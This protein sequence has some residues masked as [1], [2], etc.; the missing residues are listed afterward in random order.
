MPNPSVLASAAVFLG[1]DIG[2]SRCRFEWWPAGAAPGG[3]APSVQPAVHGIEATVQGL[4]TALFAAC[5]ERV[6]TAAVGALAGVGDAATSA[7]I[8][9]G[10]RA[11]GIAFPVAVVGDV[12]AAVAAALADGPGLLL[13]AGTGSFA[14]ARAGDGSLHRVGGRGYLLG[15]QGS[16]YD[17]VRRAAAA[18]L[19]ALDGLGPATTL[20]AALTEAFG[21]PSPARLG[22]VLQ[23]LAPGEVAGRLPHVLAAA[24]AGDQV[25]NAVLADGVAA[26]AM[27][28]AAAVR[29]AG[30]SFGGLPIAIGGGVLTGVPT[31]AAALAGRL[32]SL[33][34][35][36]PRVIAP[37]AAALGA[38]WLAAGWHEQRQPQQEWVHRV[39]I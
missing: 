29:A 9:A 12:M 39:A 17:L 16:G 8:V 26:L 31:I 34:A 20:T 28:G 19:L 22:A 33:G 5:R 32:Q 7:A 1:L 36:A 27:L 37:R 30:L 6:P 14:I 15:D 23:R 21:A 24:A 18:V 38:A 10:L 4:A 35:T 2:G 13:W 11:R 25:A 3:D